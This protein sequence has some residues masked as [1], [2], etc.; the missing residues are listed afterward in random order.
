MKC[1][2][3]SLTSWPKCFQIL[4]VFVTDS[5][6]MPMSALTTSSISFFFPLIFSLPYFYG[7]VD[8]GDYLK[9]NGFLWVEGLIAAIGVTNPSVPS[10]WPLSTKI[11]LRTTGVIKNQEDWWIGRW[12][13]LFINIYI[14][15]ACLKCRKG[16]ISFSPFSLI[17]N[18]YSQY[19]SLSRF[20]RTI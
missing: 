3:D 14:D 4:K 16:C 20:T 8:V 15:L 5:Q 12:I 11:P 2:V 1:C 6:L 19:Q 13:D 7:A 17:R 9:K 10:T 18:T